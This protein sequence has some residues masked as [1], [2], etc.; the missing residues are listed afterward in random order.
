[1]VL[2]RIIILVT[3]A[4][5]SEVV[6]AGEPFVVLNYGSQ[7]TQKGSD[8][9][10]PF[11]TDPNFSSKHEVIKDETLSDIIKNYYGGSGMNF[12]FVQMAIVQINKTAF[13]RGNP[14]FMYAGKM[15]HLPSINEITSLILG[16]GTGSKTT[17]R[18][19]R[20]DEIFFF[21]S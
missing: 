2:A 16:D 13:V 18:F 5:V 11:V 7:T 14:N 17:D 19:E 12:K 21:G 4:F 1:M 8:N 6:V 15:I 20:R 3:A 9:M 10:H